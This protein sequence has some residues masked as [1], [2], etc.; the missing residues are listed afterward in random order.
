MENT[1]SLS[2]ILYTYI[3]DHFPVYHID[4]SV[5]VPLHGKSFKKRVYSIANMERFSTAVGEKDW[6][7]VLQNSNAQSAYTVFYN[8]FCDVYNTCFPMKNFKQGY[9][10]RKPWLSEGMKNLIKT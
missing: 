4:Y 7:G 6:N 3:S 2:G 10:T 8:E 1:S 5:S 9:R